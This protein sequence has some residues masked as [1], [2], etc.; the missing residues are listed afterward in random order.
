[1]SQENVEI[2][3][4]SFEAWNRGDLNAWLETFDPKV[5]WHMSGVFPGLDTAY[6][7]HDGVRSFWRE[8]RA[9]WEEI[10]PDVEQI[11]DRGE[12]VIVLFRFRATGRDGIRVQRPQAI[13]YTVRGGQ[14]VRAENFAGWDEALKAVG[15]A[16]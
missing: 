9:G 5:E 4:D 1:M 7:G 16:E 14:V 13:C 3:R 6:Y 8:F 2:V 10:I 11:I 12:Q 15:L